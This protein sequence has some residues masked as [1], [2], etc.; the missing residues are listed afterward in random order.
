M[1]EKWCHGMSGLG[2]GKVKVV[3]SILCDHNLAV[4]PRVPGYAAGW[5][6]RRNGDGTLRPVYIKLK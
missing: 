2:W 4:L 5:V 6:K 3:I 1:R